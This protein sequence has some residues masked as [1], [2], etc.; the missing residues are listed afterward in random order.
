VALKGH[1]LTAVTK[2]GKKKKKREAPIYKYYL[3]K[4]R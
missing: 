4:S 3:K 1:E 2:R